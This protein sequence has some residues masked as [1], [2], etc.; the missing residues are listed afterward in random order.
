[1][2]IDLSGKVGLVTGAA[3]GIGR[4][5]AG[6]LAEAG[7][8]VLLV[9][10]QAEA[11]RAAAAEIVALGGSAEFVETDV[12][13]ATAVAA[14]VER[15]RASHPALHILVNN[16]GLAI[17]KG[18]AETEPD[19]WDRLMAVDLRALFLVTRACLPWLQAGV[20]ASVVHIAS[21][22]A[23]LTVATMTAYAAAKGGVV[24]MTRSMAQELGPRGI[25]VNAVSPG[26]VDTPLFRGWLAGEPDREASLRRVHDIIPVGRLATPTEVGQLVAFLA[27]DYA[28]S[29]HGA[30]HVI[31]GGLTT[32]LKH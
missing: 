7:A 17:F 30:N 32:D 25:R 11:G 31:D 4:G 19:D 27:S 18:L 6:V 9:D 15:L 16:A 12:A 3:V 28:G 21:V 2:K 5:I 20:P 22:H 10:I 14:M 23:A 1:M 8:H 26:F 29:I 13:D 24:A